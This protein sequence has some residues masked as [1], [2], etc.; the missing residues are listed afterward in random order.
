DRYNNVRLHSAIGY[1][2]PKDTL[3]GR[4][5]E[6]HTERDR[7]LEAARQQRQSRR[8]RAARRAKW[9]AA[10]MSDNREAARF[11]IA[12]HAEIECGTTVGRP[13]CDVTLLRPAP[14]AELPFS[15]DCHRQTTAHISRRYI[16]RSHPVARSL[17]EPSLEY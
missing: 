13:R 10:A 12:D 8:Q 2:T 15:S 1:V 11:R 3:A 4:Q 14:A 7:K 16:R 9:P 6:I 5:V 17:R